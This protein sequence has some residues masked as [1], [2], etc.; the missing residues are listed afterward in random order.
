[1]VVYVN[2]I[3]NIFNYKLSKIVIIYKNILIYY[4]IMDNIEMNKNLPEAIII[5][6][7]IPIVAIQ[8]NEEI[9]PE[10]IASQ[11]NN[12]NNKCEYYKYCMTIPLTLLSITLLIYYNI[13]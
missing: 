11:I 8:V 4:Y 1:M 2:I 7:P 9:L 12:N 5:E 13:K 3:Y 6:E 10:I